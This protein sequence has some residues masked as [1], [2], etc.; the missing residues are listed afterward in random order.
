MLGDREGG[1]AGVDREDGITGEVFGEEGGKI[2][3]RADASR[4]VRLYR[5]GVDKI[6]WMFEE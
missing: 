6:A 5:N 4:K 1:D 3:E 2:R